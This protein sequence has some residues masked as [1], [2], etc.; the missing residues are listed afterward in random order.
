MKKN[1]VEKLLFVI[2]TALV[3]FWAITTYQAERLTDAVEAVTDVIYDTG[4]TREVVITTADWDVIEFTS[5]G[6]TKRE[7]E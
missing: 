5:G 4:D 3:A 2:I 6:V 1:L 7:A